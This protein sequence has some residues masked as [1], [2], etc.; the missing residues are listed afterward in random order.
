MLI[1]NLFSNTE[2]QQNIIGNTEYN[3]FVTVVNGNLISNIANNLTTYN[4]ITKAENIYINGN[5]DN[6]NFF[7]ILDLFYPSVKPNVNSNV[8]STIQNY[9][10]NI[11][12]PYYS[13][14]VQNIDINT[15]NSIV[16]NV[17]LFNYMHN[18]ANIYI[19]GNISNDGLYD[20]LDL[21]YPNVKANVNSNLLDIITL[22][23]GNVLTP[24]YS[25]IATNITLTEINNLVSNVS[26]YNYLQKN[27]NVYINGNISN[28]GLYFVIDFLYPSIKSNVTNNLLANIQNYSANLLSPSYTNA[29]ANIDQSILNNLVSNVSIYDYMQKNAN[30]YING[31]ISNDGFYTIMNLLYPVVK[32]NININLLST[33]QNYS[34][35]L[36][37]PHYT[38]L[39]ENIDVNTINNLSANVSIY[40]YMQKNANIYYIDGNINTDKLYRIA[41]LLYPNVKNNING[42]LLPIIQNYSGNLLTP[43]YTPV[44]ENINSN[45]LNDRI[46][47]VNLYDYMQKNANVYI[48]G[49]IS[50]DELYSI[51]DL[52][53]PNVKSNVNNKLINTLNTYSANILSPYYTTIATNI[54]NTI[55]NSIVANTSLYTYMQK[56][57]NANININDNVSNDEL[58]HLM[59]FLYPSIKSNVNTTL[60]STITNYSGNVLNP[61]YSD[62]TANI[63]INVLANL[64]NELSPY[65]YMQN[66]ANI[67]INGNLSTDGLYRTMHLLFPIV[68]STINSELLLTIETY[69]NTLL[70]PTYTPFISN[71]NNDV[72]N[73]L[74]NGLNLYTYMQNNSNIYNNGNINGNINTPGLYEMMDFLFDNK[75]IISTFTNYSGNILS[76][77]YTPFTSNINVEIISNLVAE[78][79]LDNYF[80]NKANLI[81]N[82]SINVNGLYNM[83]NLLYPNVK[84]YIDTELLA[85]ITNYSGNLLMPY[86]TP[87]VSNIDLITLNNLSSNQT[88]YQFAQNNANIYINGSINNDGFYTMMDLLYPIVKSTLD[89]ELLLT[90]TN[91]K[92]TLLSPTYTPFI[93]NINS[94][95][96][97]TLLNGL[98]IY[99]YVQNNANIDING[100]IQSN[101][102]YNMIDFVFDT[103]IIIS[104]MKKYS[105]N[106]LSPY[107]TEFAGNINIIEIGNLYSNI[108]ITNYIR[109]KSNLY[110][111]GN[112]S[113]DT[114]YYFADA[115]YPNVKSNVN[116]QLLSTIIN[117][118]GNILLPYYSPI[119][120]NVNI[121]ILDTIVNGV[122]L[123]NYMQKN[124]NLYY[125]NGN[126]NN[127]E[128]YNMLDFLYPNVKVNINNALI[129]T[130]KQYS[131]NLLAPYYT[132]IA[133]NIDNL[134]LNTLLSKSSLYSYMQNNANANIAIDGNIGN[135]ELYHVMD[136]LY[137]SVKTT[138]NTDL[139]NTINNNRGNILNP[140]YLSYVQNLNINT[141]NSRITEVSLYKYMLTNGNVIINDNVNYNYLYRVLDLLH[142]IV[143]ETTDI[144]ILGT[145]IEYK[146][147]FLKPSYS[148]FIG[149]IDEN[150]LSNIT[151]ETNLYTYLNDNT[152]IEINGN[153]NYDGLYKKMDLV[154]P[155]LKESINSELLVT[156][157]TINP[158]LIG[159]TFANLTANINNNILDDLISNVS[160]Y[161]Y[162]TYNYNLYSN[163]TLDLDKL[164]D[165]LNLLYFNININTDT[166]NFINQIRYNLK[167]FKNH[168]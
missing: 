163:D 15:I 13:P 85:T 134:S 26:L 109:N 140:F 25:S 39:V 58:Y 154:F 81:I 137:P 98:S 158:N 63:D 45:I 79:G 96:I 166:K 20:M 66:T 2:I 124:A 69:K 16:S 62:F 84:P 37:S 118:S 107:Y 150:I 18:S 113:N 75:T 38:Q 27:G 42:N 6:D 131:G 114:V 122:N 97:N 68:K 34:G 161:N 65:T 32:S 139:L 9:S 49:N 159:N 147:T 24:Y 152:N 103:N 4:Y 50:N 33:I 149:N 8:L 22:Y 130:V 148:K 95:T 76:P 71:I 89:S 91:F 143:K 132:L 44:V 133:N 115:L 30:I 28:D 121:D 72:I 93:A 116:N 1:S 87:F 99:T 94:N 112:I 138:V 160:F 74:L 43:Y 142:P 82:G 19:N 151:Y 135:D 29:V 52:L 106:V 61:Y 14:V 144:E 167:M 10:G 117:Y 51:I 54:N 153:I 47:N 119:V 126:I 146:D 127:D 64:V 59:D 108:G 73:N 57:A 120:A 60:L 40:D 88:L 162:I 48:N 41:D 21:L 164:M 3:T 35:N 129:S 100:N 77:Y 53:Y 105:S 123:Y 83:A 168:M 56:N 90:I 46:E 31:N 92:D 36:L 104:T 157:K 78:I 101:G 145:I 102:L 156:L 11:L 7:G 67:Y 80:Q 12:T 110:I 111:N 136:F 17:S 23:S 70:S 155:N 5:I 55:L 86:Y 128:L 165:I 141:L 125:I